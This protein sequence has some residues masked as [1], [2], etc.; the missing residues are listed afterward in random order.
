MTVLIVLVIV[1]IALSAFF[2]GVEAALFSIPQSKVHVF[3]EQKRRGAEALAKVKKNLPRAIMIIVVGNNAV[4]IAGSMFVGVVATRVFGDAVIGIVSA[5]VTLLIIIFGEIL[6]KTIGENNADRISLMAAPLILFLQ[7]V[8]FP[9]IWVF[10]RLTRPFMKENATV[11]EEEIHVLSEIGHKEG[12]IE[13]DEKDIIQRVFTLNDITAEDIMTPRT[14]VTALQKDERLGDIKEV[15]FELNYSRIP[16]YEESLDDIVGICYRK[17]LLIALAK[18]EEDKKVE[19]FVQDVLYIDEDMR[20]DDLLQLFLSRR[21]QIAIVKDK[22]DGT[23]GIVTLE[24]VLEQLVGEIVDEDDEVVDTRA[25]AESEG[26]KSR[27]H[28]HYEADTLE[29]EKER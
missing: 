6:P 18:D 4:N 22:F 16:V 17:Q 7:K 19:D 3:L 10:E 15:I 14:V 24:D 26:R 1:V 21:E 8:F 25:F 28:N 12:S 11:S 23:S 20:V 29:N 13:K 27:A 9:V 5:V 2:A